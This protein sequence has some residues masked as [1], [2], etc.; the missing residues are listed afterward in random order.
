MWKVR[1]VSVSES[2]SAQGEDKPGFGAMVVKQWQVVSP[3]QPLNLSVAPASRTAVV[4]LCVCM[5]VC[6]F[7]VC[8]LCQ[9][10]LVLEKET[11]WLI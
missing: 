11:N 2:G 5:C 9:S 10:S 3:G 4:C 7:C 8:E 6:V 1:A